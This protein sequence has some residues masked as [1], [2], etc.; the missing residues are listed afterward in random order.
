MSEKKTDKS[1]S[2]LDA[3]K[4]NNTSKSNTE[5]AQK[6]SATEKSTK[7]EKNQNAGAQVPDQ[8]K[9]ST[10]PL[11]FIVT[12][13]VVV[14]IVGAA[15]WYLYDTQSQF[16]HRF[17]Q[18]LQTQ[19]SSTEQS[20]TKLSTLEQ[21]LKRSKNQ[22]S[23]AQEKIALLEDQVSDLSQALQ[24][25]T[26]SGSEL[27]LLNDVAHFIDLAQQQL[28][29]G[30]NVSNAI[31]PLE[32]AQA[33]LVRSDRQSLGILLQAIN[34]DLDRLRA[35]ERVDVPET[36]KQLEKLLTWL[37]EAPLLAPQEH[38]IALFE[39]HEGETISQLPKSSAK[40][41]DSE[42]WEES[43]DVAQ[44]WAQRAWSNMRSELGELISVQRVD[45]ATVLLMTPEQVQ[46]LREHIR[47]RVSMAQLALMT[48]QNEIW[49]MELDTLQRIIEKRFDLTNATT[50]RALGLVREL[51]K[52]NVQPKLPTL[53][54][55][56]AAV[57]NLRQKAAQQANQAEQQKIDEAAHI[58]NE[59]FTSNDALDAD[60]KKVQ[61]EKN[62]KEEKTDKL[63][64][65][66]AINTNTNE[67][68][69]SHR[70]VTLAANKQSKQ[71]V[72]QALE[73]RQ[74]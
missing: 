63:S 72:L 14:A 56:L 50:Q 30:G 53:D 7:N 44:S 45:D 64:S 51:E 16:K 68:A 33:R 19:L 1:Q 42:W 23:N 31:I 65:N 22:L 39:E 15:V 57:E 49:Q 46:G 43:L 73:L 8:K 24:I 67:N 27:M 17:E 35:V 11:P 26:D 4:T 9:N 28:L 40:K 69:S 48:R 3:K 55:T 66:N 60:D 18:Q 38:H 74:G 12:V 20:S 52:L 54:N 62:N 61:A 71:F 25:M 10:K 37:T 32:T 13:L 34:G 5:S 59:A 6:P 41:D 29:V 36:L 2:D 70:Q 21:D 47:L 58:G